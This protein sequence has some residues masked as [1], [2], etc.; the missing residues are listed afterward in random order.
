MFNILHWWNS[1]DRHAFPSK[2]LFYA[3]YLVWAVFIITSLFFGNLVIVSLFPVSYFS[4]RTFRRLT[5]PMCHL[6]WPI[7]LYCWEV[8]GHNQTVYY[9]DQLPSHENAIVL[10]NHISY[11]DWVHAFGLAKRKGMLGC[12]KVTVKAA[13]RFIPIIGTSLVGMG[14]VFMSRNWQ[15]DRLKLD[16]AFGALTTSHLPFWLLVHPEGS[17]ATPQKLKESQEFAG[18]RNLPVLKHVLLPRVKGF[19]RAVFGLRDGIKAVYDLTVVY[20]SHPRHLWILWSGS[21]P[22]TAHVVVR[23]FPI[24]TLPKDEDGLAEWLYKLYQEKDKLIEEYKQNG[25]YTSCPTYKEPLDVKEIER[26]MKVWVWA[27][28]AGYA[29]CAFTIYQVATRFLS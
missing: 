2:A 6:A 26:Q 20:T 17:R 8:T 19:S 7:F 12:I 29:F 9:G 18:N 5:E 16:K 14:F 27:M 11:M 15:T 21:A 3:G 4:P 28:S 1:L 24:E 10:T 25:K 13:I 23:R 22:I